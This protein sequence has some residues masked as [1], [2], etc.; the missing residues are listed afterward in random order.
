MQSTR[1]AILGG[2]AML[3]LV[4]PAFAQAREM[5]QVYKS[6]SCGCCGAWVEHMRR[7]G[8]SVR[9]TDVD[10]LDAVKARFGVPDELASCHTA[11]VAGYVV[12]GHVPAGDVRRLLAERPRATGLAV[13][14]MP[15]G[16]PGMEQGNTREP[17]QTIL[18]DR[19]TRRVFA[20]H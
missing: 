1:R 4:G 10:D 16:S 7:A 11:I 20:R 17:Y 14:G 9:A 3:A 19:S 8:F 2:A 12:E 18:F 13:P 15:I 5:V 6:A